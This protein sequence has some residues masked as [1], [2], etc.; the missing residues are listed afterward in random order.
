V[1][2]A[3]ISQAFLKRKPSK[4]PNVKQL[5]KRVCVPLVAVPMAP[6]AAFGCET[7]PA[8]R[9][10]SLRQVPPSKEPVPQVLMQAKCSLW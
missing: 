4:T 7:L 2:A 8:R 9:N 3:P 5:L 6:I 1:C 10:V